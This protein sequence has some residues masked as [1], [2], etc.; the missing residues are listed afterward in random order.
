MGQAQRVLHI[1]LLAIAMYVA[2]FFVF[3]LSFGLIGPGIA[4][5]LTSLLTLGLTINLVIKF[6]PGSDRHQERYD[7]MA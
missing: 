4:A 2:L 6:K 7:R 5:I 3:T 1:H